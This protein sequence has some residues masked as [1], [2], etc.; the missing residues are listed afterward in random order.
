MLK[1]LDFQLDDAIASAGSGTTIKYID[2]YTTLALSITNIL[3]AIFKTSVG[4][5]GV[6]LI[7]SKYQSSSIFYSVI[8]NHDPVMDLN[9]KY[10]IRVFY[11]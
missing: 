7:Y 2:T 4:N 11:F 3:G 5:T 9:S 6:G 10:D 8:L 1:F